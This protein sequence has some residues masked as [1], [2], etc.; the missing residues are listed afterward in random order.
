MAINSILRIAPD[1]RNFLP[2]ALHLLVVR[3]HKGP[4][5]DR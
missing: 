1:K 5:Y 3:D 4:R 2:P